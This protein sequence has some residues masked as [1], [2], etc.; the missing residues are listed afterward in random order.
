MSTTTSTAHRPGILLQA[1]W[2]ALLFG[3]IEG[4]LY[5]V[6]A[7]LTFLIRQTVRVGPGSIWMPS[8]TNLVLFLAAG[9]AL[10]LLARWRPGWFTPAVVTGVL[11]GLGV[12]SLLL[13][14]RPLHYVASFVLAAGIGL[15]LGGPVA[16][17]GGGFR[18]L[19]RWSLPVLF[20]ALGG[21]VAWTTVLAERREARTLASLPAP[22]PDRPNILFIILDTVRDFSTGLGGYERPT[23]PTLVAYAASSTVFDAAIATAPWTMPSHASMFT[24]RYP[25]ELGIDFDVGLDDHYP[26]VAE[27]FRDHGYA[28][29]GFVAN[30]Y[31]SRLFGLDRG[32]VHYEDFPVDVQQLLLHASLGR[33]LVPKLVVPAMRKLGNERKFGRKPAP[34]VTGNFLEWSRDTGGRPF[35]AFLN[36]MEAHH[37]YQPP[38]PY[39]RM[40]TPPEQPRYRAQ[41][42]N[43]KRVAE[44]PRE[45]EATRNAYDGSI[46]YLD[47][48]LEL[49][50]T[51]LE[52]RGQLEH[53]VIVV[54]ADH[55]EHLGE[56]A[57]MYHGNSV[58]RQ[59]LQVPLLL[60]WPARVP[61]GR[62]VAEPVTLRDLGATLLDLAGFPEER[63]IP[64]RSWRSSWDSTVPGAPSAVRAEL[65]VGANWHETIFAEGYQLVRSHD[66]PPRLFAVTTDRA[67]LHD[68]AADST[69]PPEVVERLGRQLDALD[70]R[71]RASGE[72]PDG[73]E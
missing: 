71:A 49:I 30:N 54:T 28:T 22:G 29:G 12:F 56:H 65:T 31:V 34:F 40:F 57:I 5:Q 51:E 17:R 52:R 2:F 37:P 55:G 8:V 23:T 59:E 38:M 66:A 27:A 1:T 45:L 16:A 36:F 25:D 73:G 50:F 6:P 21:A 46:A 33:F 61:A 9:A 43:P 44:Q 69:V 26:T 53:T 72:R 20:A 14:Y 58:Y 19:V 4:T 24:G 10:A 13:L 70:I 64:G 47:H 67:N 42:L 3:A 32:F 18:T 60:R 15:R 68:L 41:A 11:L 39:E 63:R 62:R 35:Y 7:V 48:Q